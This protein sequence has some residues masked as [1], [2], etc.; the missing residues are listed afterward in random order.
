MVNESQRSVIRRVVVVVMAICLSTLPLLAQRTKAAADLFIIDDIEADSVSTVW[1][2]AGLDIRL[3][4]KKPEATTETKRNPTDGYRVVVYIGMGSK[5][6]SE[7]L[8]RER[9]INSSFPQY[10]TYRYF[11]QSKWIVVVGDFKQREDAERLASSIRSRFRAF[12]RE[13]RVVESTIKN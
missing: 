1:Q 8:S 10:R 13:V 5:A 9:Q 12:Q 4:C 6:A 7:S 2:P 3:R 11:R